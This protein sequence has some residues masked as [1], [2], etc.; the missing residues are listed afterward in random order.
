MALTV[1]CAIVV[2]TTNSLEHLIPGLSMFEK[3]LMM[4]AVEVGR[5][6]D[7]V[8]T[9]Q[10]FV[11]TNQLDDQQSNDQLMIQHIVF[12]FKFA[13]S[14]LIPDVPTWVREQHA[15]HTY[16]AGMALKAAEEKNKK[17]DK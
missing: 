9:T 5:S 16:M 7:F 4:V 6:F 1:N 11:S 17:G 2:F 12:L 3:L 13:I 15:R 14:N 8:V 10:S